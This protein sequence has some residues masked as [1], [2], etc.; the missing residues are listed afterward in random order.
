MRCALETR[1][2]NVKRSVPKFAGPVFALLCAAFFFAFL[3]G[4][5]SS[6][7][8]PADRSVEPRLPAVSIVPF[9]G[10][11]LSIAIMPL[12]AGH[13]WERNRNK[14]L[15]AA[16]FS[17]PVVAFLVLRFGHAGFESLVEMS[18]EYV[19]FITILAALFV[20]AG[21]ILIEGSFAGTPLANTGML[22]FGA[23][24]ANVVGTTGASMVLVRPLI[25]ANKDRRKIAHLLVFFIFVVSNCGGLLTP[26]GDPPL[27]LGYLAGVPFTWTLR[28]FPQWAF[29][30]GVLLVTFYAFDQIML[31]RDKREH[32]DDLLGKVID[33]VPL[34]IR[35]PHNIGF[36]LATVV[37]VFAAGRGFGNGGHPWPFGVCEAL[38]IA[39]A[40]GAYASTRSAIRERNRFTFTPI[41]EVAVLFAGIFLTM[42]PA[43]L[44]LNEQGSTIGLRQPWQYFW[45]SGLLSSVLDNAPTYLTFVAA[46]SGAQ[47][48]PLEGRYL[49]NF[50]ELDAGAGANVLAAIS[51][52]CVFMGANTYIGNAPNFLVRVIAEQEN[53][54]MPS[55]FGYV[56][57]SASILIPLFGLATI[58][59]FSA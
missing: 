33:Q 18:R 37:T 38:L 3:C 11:L 2:R 27:F 9:V 40:A 13:W 54:R 15:V 12:A 6:G 25:R 49:A 39:L 4:A 56:A 1:V 47:G 21:G 45:A 53:V 42:I 41:A 24:L 10:L 44:L 7:E 32:C 52:G 19:S 14:A 59:F 43:L 30:N 16:V 57:Y 51:C 35:G 17:L 50:L 28:L 23:V 36:L 58:L 26:L 22:A 34:R 8:P 20:I 48:I 55:F 31:V 5:G 46:A 29:I